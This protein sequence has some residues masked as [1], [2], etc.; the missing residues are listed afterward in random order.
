[1]TEALRAGRTTPAHL[2]QQ[3][4]QRIDDVDRAGPCINS[5]LSLNPAAEADAAGA[6]P[7]GPLHGIPVLVKD[8]LDT[9]GLATTAGSTALVAGAPG[10]DADV[11]ARLRRAGA[12]IVGKANLSEWANFRG[13]RSTSGW[14]AVGGLTLNPHALDRT[15]GG[16][17]TGSAAAVA[18]GLVPVAIGTETDGS[19][20]CPAA[21]CG[22]VGV[23]PT[24]G[25]TSRAGVVPISASQ[26]TVGPFA[27]TV[28]DAALALD[29][30]AAAGG[31]VA[32]LAEGARGLRV[33]VA[34]PGTWGN[35]VEMDRLCQLAVDA[36]RA[37]GVE[38][39]DDV[40]LPA[41]DGLDQDELLVLEYEFAAGLAD[42]LATR[43]GGPK[44]VHDLIAHNRANAEAELRWFGQ[45]HMEAAAETKGLDE[46]EY[47]EALER[48]RRAGREDGI[49]K[50]L[51]EH[52]V[53]ALVGP[54]MSPAWKIDLVNG[55]PAGL[56]SMSQLPAVAGYPAVTVPVGLVDGLPVGLAFCGTARSEGVLL[57]LADAVER[58]VGPPPP[59]AYRPPAT[60]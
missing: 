41:A 40:P 22:V 55:D 56:Y 34:R 11:V 23:K 31:H 52:R 14:S 45:E 3:A 36:L 2:L 10:S 12:V 35:N 13:R 5:V 17:S 37:A 15:A 8:N 44:T 9:A 51:A 19:I 58:A 33:G 49:D 42:Y 27:R 48:A 4:R 16:S 43:D 1:M 59:P 60:G 32:A 46:P 28:H 24:V 30:I 57:R 6:L 18:A 29:A 54:T 47:R 26:D 38:V 20:L 53:D 39:V 7:D 25:L 21:V 50:A